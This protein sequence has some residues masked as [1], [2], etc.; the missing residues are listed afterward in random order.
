[1]PSILMSNIDPPIQLSLK[2]EA[3]PYKLNFRHCG[4]EFTYKGVPTV[5]CQFVH[6]VIHIINHS[7]LTLFSSMSGGTSSIEVA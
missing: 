1:M 5:H 4:T 6:E 3:F 7:R 2:D